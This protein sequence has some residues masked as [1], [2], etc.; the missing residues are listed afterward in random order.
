MSEIQASLKELKNVA[1]EMY[2]LNKKMKDLRNRKR[3]L[4]ES[5]IEY[6]ESKDKNGVRFDNIVFAVTAKNSR[7][8]KKKSEIVRDTTD[9][10]KRYG[11]Q[12]NIQTILEELEATRKGTASAVP[13]LRMKSAGIFG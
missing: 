6:L 5:V 3:E 2:N 13:V 12:G 4:E 8:Q 1:Q 9:V 11:I 7:Q 10:L